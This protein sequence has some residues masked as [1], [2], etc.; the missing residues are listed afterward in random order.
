MVTNWEEGGK[1]ITA[2]GNCQVFLDSSNRREKT[3]KAK[4]AI[5]NQGLARI[6][7]P[8]LNREFVIIFIQLL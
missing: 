3:G 6:C 7:T 4:I 2:R 1:R 5:Y 8:D